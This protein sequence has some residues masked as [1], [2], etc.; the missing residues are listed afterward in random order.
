MDI[1]LYMRGLRDGHVMLSAVKNPAHDL[2]YV[3][4]SALLVCGVWHCIQ[5]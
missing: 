4:I 5:Q 2:H 3:E 1:Q